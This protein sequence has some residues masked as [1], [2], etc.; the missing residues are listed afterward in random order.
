VAQVLNCVRL[1]LAMEYRKFLHQKA[2][3]KSERYG[4]S[5]RGLRT[6]SLGGIDEP[7][8]VRCEPSGN[9]ADARL[10]GIDSARYG[11]RVSL[12]RHAL[13]PLRTNDAGAACRCRSVEGDSRMSRVRIIAVASETAGSP[14]FKS[15]H[16]FVDSEAAQSEVVELI[17]AVTLGSV[18]FK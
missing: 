7:G 16:G 14:V 13:E 6:V 2:R 9:Q 3:S 17:L 1:K 12:S 5:Q 15:T 11:V 8:G 18:P 4:R 10:A